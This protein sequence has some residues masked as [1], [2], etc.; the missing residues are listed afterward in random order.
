LKNH[1][2]IGRAK[3][4]A[5]I[6]AAAFAFGSAVV[7]AAAQEVSK[8][9]SGR[10]V[11]IIQDSAAARTVT[12]VYEGEFSYVR[13][14]RAE[15]AAAPN[16]HPV[17]VPPEVLKKALAGVRLHNEP[18]FND[19][20]LA[21]IVPPLVTALARATPDEDVSFAVPGRHAGWA[22]LSPRSV[23]TGRMFRDVD[24][25]E[26]IVGLAQRPFEDEFNATGVLIAFEPGHRAA[27]VD[28]KLRLSDNE[29]GSIVRRGDWVSLPIG[30]ALAA[31]PPAA[32]PA[33]PAGPATP[34][35]AMPAPAPAI[36]PVPATAPQAAPAGPAT[37]AAAMPIPAPAA[38]PTTGLSPAPAAP[39]SAGAPVAAPVAPAAVPSARPQPDAETLY[40]AI[41]ERLKALQRLRDNGLITQQEY[42]QK[43]RQILSDL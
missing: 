21:Q 43:R 38:A 24:G 10:A 7:P 33:V 27:P 41:S 31:A 32:A 12:K 14:E 1:K 37:P 28:P 17:A 18:L 23:T 22:I 40:R 39:Q 13:I 2:P 15:P 11:H 26:L 16:L 35:A 20:E 6:V 34:A 3:V 42:E 36:A 9:A 4:A 8:G 25:L 19:D 30:A 5:R 29:P